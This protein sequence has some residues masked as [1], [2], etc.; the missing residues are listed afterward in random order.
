MSFVLELEQDQGCG[1]DLRDA[2]GVE[3]D[4]AQGLEGGFQQGV[5]PFADSVDASDD[6]GHVRHRRILVEPVLVNERV[7]AA[8][9]PLMSE[10][11]VLDV[12]RGRAALLRLG[13]DLI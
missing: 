6:L 2:A 3:A 1:G 7:E 13:R 11:H 12:V 10:L 8:L 5:G 9:G 4:P